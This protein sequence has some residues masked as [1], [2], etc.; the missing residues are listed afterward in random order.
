MAYPDLPFPSSITE[1]YVG[2][3]EVLDYLQEYASHF[4]LEKYI[5]VRTKDFSEY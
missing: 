3:K 1:S 5:R 2:H 4:D